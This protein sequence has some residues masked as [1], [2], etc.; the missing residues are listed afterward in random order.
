LSKELELVCT[1]CPMSC[2]MKVRIEGDRIEVSGNMCPRGAEYA[3]QE[4]TNPVRYV[5]T[6]ARVRGGDIPTVS[7]ITSRPVPKSCM[8]KVMEATANLEL[9]A[10]IELGQVVLRNICGAD[11]IATRRVR[12]V[13]HH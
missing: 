13:Q 12:K 10:P 9:E 2:T 3:K 6:V 7:L 8:E 4:V 1:L 11:L 5:M